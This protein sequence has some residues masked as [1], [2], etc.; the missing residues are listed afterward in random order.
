[1]KNWQGQ[2]FPIVLLALLAG[3][4]FWL[5]SAVNVEESRRDGKLRH[6]PDAIVDNFTV[7]R[8][9][10]DGQIK[11]RLTAPYLEHY[12]DDDSSELRS[13]T[14]VHIRSDAPS[15]TF[16]ALNARVSAGGETVFLWDDV[17][18]S[19]AATADRPEL[20]AK[21]PDLTVEPDLGTAFTD[22]PVEITMGQSWLKGT[23]ARI[24]NNAATFALQSQVTGLYVRPEKTP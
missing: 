20:L 3:L 1:M 10:A 24:D 15:I 6:D 5:Q 12:P 2:L 23:G 17:R 13:P 4:S 18:V 21:M 19:R 8:F 9:D 11:Y 14:L 22:S 7:R 16:R